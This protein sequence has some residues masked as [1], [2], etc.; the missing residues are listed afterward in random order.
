MAGGEDISAT[1]PKLL[2]S[3]TRAI[4]ITKRGRVWKFNIRT[5]VLGVGS[6]AKVSDAKNRKLCEDLNEVELLEF[7]DLFG[8]T[9][10]VTG[11]YERTPAYDDSSQIGS[12]ITITLEEKR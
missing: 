4:P 2:S 1:G 5:E 7:K 9:F 12:L 3:V 8:N 6:P 11:S 10:N